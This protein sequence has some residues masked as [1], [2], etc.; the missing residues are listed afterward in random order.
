MD[1][2][3]ASLRN[4]AGSLSLWMVAIVLFSFTGCTMHVTKDIS[5]KLDPDGLYKTFNVE[6]R[7]LS[8]RSKCSAPP[9]VKIVNAETR[10]E[11]FEALQNPPVSGFINPK[12]MVDRVCLYLKDGFERSRI[13]G[14]DQSNKVIQLKLEDLKA[15]AGVWSF[16]SY[17]KIQL[18]I[19]ETR[20]TKFYEARDNSGLGHTAAAYAIHGVTRQII[21]DPEIQDYLLC[22]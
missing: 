20:L 4:A 5:N 6:P 12:E 2:K 18:T 22:R 17:F 19:P 21:D 11:D 3:N 1:G 7:D 15:I 13:K 10:T 16:G 8:A 9:T 14:D